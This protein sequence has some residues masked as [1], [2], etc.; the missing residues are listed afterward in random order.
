MFRWDRTVLL[1]PPFFV[2]GDGERRVPCN[3]VA[4]ESEY[5]AVD[6]GSV[7]E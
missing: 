3:N 6:R 4:G 1:V 2:D 7:F 5:A